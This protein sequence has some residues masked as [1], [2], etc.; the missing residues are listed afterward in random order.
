MRAQQATVSLAGFVVMPP[1]IQPETSQAQSG[2]RRNALSWP[3]TSER[4][5]KEHYQN[6]SRPGEVVV[7]VPT[8]VR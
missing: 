4:P 1:Q 7:R 6:G 8:G 3:G 5:E 2:M